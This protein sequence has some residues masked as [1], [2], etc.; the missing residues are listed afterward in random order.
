MLAWLFTMERR[1]QRILRQTRPG[2][3]RDYLAVPFPAR[4]ADWHG[5]DFVA[6]DLETTGLDFSRDEILSVGM[7]ELRGGCIRLDTAR[8]LLVAPEGVVPERSAVIH[9]LTDDQVAAGRP[10]GKVLP[11]VLE[12]LAGRVLLCHHA[13][14]ETGFLDAACRRLYGA[15]FVALV[16]DT[17][18]LIG[19]W[20]E[21]RN[22]AP[23]P[24]G[25]RLHSLR[26]RFNLPRYKAHD[27]LID[28]LATAELFCAFAAHRELGSDPSLRHFLSLG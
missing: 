25:L 4:S 21:Q 18:W 14:I 22:Q 26:E 6:L 23:A 3:L 12:R 17:E 1:R 9:Q 5:V 10:L 15:P 28:A 16:A 19:R 8:H 24:G 2:P 20:L 27:A 13:G 11:E 7:I